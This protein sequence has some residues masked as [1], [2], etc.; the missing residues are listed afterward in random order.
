MKIYL[1][2]LFIVSA[3]SLTYADAEKTIDIL[4]VKP[5]PHRL[6]AQLSLLNFTDEE[7]LI[8]WVTPDFSPETNPAL[9]SLEKNAFVRLRR[10]GA[11]NLTPE[12]M[13]PFPPRTERVITLHLELPKGG[14][15]PGEYALTMTHPLDPKR[16]DSHTFSI[17]GQNRLPR[18]SEFIRFE[19][20]PLPGTAPLKTNADLTADY[21]DLFNLE[22][23]RAID[24]LQSICLST[25]STL[26]T[27]FKNDTLRSTLFTLYDSLLSTI[28]ATECI[29]TDS[30]PLIVSQRKRTQ[31]LAAIKRET[32]IEVLSVDWSSG[33]SFRL[34]LFN[35]TGQDATLNWITPTHCEGINPILFRVDQN[36]F[37]LPHISDSPHPDAGSTTAF[38]Q[39][40]EQNITVCM[41]LPEDALA[42]GAYILTVTH[43]L[44]PETTASHS[45]TIEKKEPPQ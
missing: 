18:R 16:M 3:A 42:P 12:F 10:W 1:S 15:P 9:F 14:L 7:S 17:T 43:P 8:H 39:K 40:T 25:I 11:R 24:T 33:F 22:F 36:E 21:F 23:E 26:D 35:H 37:L 2:L 38:P 30:G 45:F 19:P 44:D 29:E 20:L 34:H 6:T 28:Y 5:S 32:P 27:L 4:S 13:M 41:N 31:R